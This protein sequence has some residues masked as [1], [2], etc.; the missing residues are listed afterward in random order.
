M[1]SHHYNQYKSIYSDIISPIGQSYR[2][3]LLKLGLSSTDL[4]EQV[5]K[6]AIKSDDANT[7]L[8]LWNVTDT[9]KYNNY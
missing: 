5:P 9:L 4:Q 1:I 3:V 2:K 7:A 8:F 6:R